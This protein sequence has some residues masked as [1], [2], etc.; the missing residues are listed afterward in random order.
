MNGPPCGMSVVQPFR[1]GVVG[2]DNIK[3][4]ALGPDEG[5]FEEIFVAEFFWRAFGHRFS[6]D[7]IHHR[8]MHRPPIV[9]VIF[10][11]EVDNQGE[12]GC[13]YLGAIL[14]L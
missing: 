6:L 9:F 10:D 13:Q 2:L 5:S 4:G 14:D 8:I 3:S 12:Q 7:L 11:H 1:R